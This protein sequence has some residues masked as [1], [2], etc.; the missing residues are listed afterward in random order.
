M[1]FFARVANKLLAQGL[2][3]YLHS[4][5]HRPRLTMTGIGGRMMAMK[6]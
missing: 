6:K 5:E 1:V 4:A 2:I 3:K